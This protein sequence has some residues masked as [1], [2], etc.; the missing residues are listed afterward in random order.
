M[1]EKARDSRANVPE[2]TDDTRSFLHSVARFTFPCV[3]AHEIGPGL[4]VCHRAT[5]PLAPKKFSERRQEETVSACLNI[6][7]LKRNQIS[8]LKLNPLLC[9]FRALSD[10]ERNF[11]RRG[12]FNAWQFRIERDKIFNLNWNRVGFSGV[13]VETEKLQWLGPSQWLTQW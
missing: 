1:R 12:N 2:E 8:C 5:E 4:A 9:Y 3:F 13:E 7:T 11:G 6:E 10:V